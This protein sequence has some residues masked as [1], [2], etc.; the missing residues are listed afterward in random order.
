MPTE[1]LNFARMDALDGEDFRNREP[2]PWLN[3][4]GLLTDAGYAA[5]RENLPDVDMFSK[6]FGVQRAHGQRSH[7]RY[8]LEYADDLDVP[9]P[10][11]AFVEELRGPRYRAFLR[12]IF[13]VR[14][15]DLNFHWHY[16]PDGCSVSPHCDARHK[17]GS[18]IFYLNTADDWR[19]E[20]GGETLILDDQGRF[21]RDSAPDFED[22]DRVISAEALG[23]RSLIFMQ[24]KNSWHGVREIRCPEGKLRK[25]FIVVIN[26]GSPV[27]RVRRFL[28]RVA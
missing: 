25:V 22:F 11:K 28:R 24:R 23:N 16:T 13:G 15:L 20:W 7:D 6:V 9:A 21:P 18:H 10:W 4:Q 8:T 12:R 5:L 27:A 19:E 3:P 2:Y 17:L 26:S 14:R 1:Y